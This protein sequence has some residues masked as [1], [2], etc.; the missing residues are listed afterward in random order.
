MKRK[1]KEQPKPEPMTVALPAEEGFLVLTRW[2]VEYLTAL[3]QAIISPRI[4]AQ[5][6]NHNKDRALGDALAHS[7][8]NARNAW[9]ILSRSNI[10]PPPSPGY[11]IETEHDRKANEES[12]KALHMNNQLRSAYG[13]VQLEKGNAEDAN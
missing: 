10:I 12:N 4:N 1:P 13:R 9:E 3:L 7:A 2:Q 8:E 5:Q 6:L 11:G